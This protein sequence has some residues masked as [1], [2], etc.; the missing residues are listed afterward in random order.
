MSMSLG[1]P[2]GTIATDDFLQLKDK[3]TCDQVSYDHLT[4][5]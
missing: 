1:H 3:H 5:P 2:Y 4:V